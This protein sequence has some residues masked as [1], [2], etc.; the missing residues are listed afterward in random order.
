MAQQI[1]DWEARRDESGN[2][3][4]Y[5]PPRNDGGGSYE[6]AG[7]NERYHPTMAAR[8]KILLEA[9]RYAQAEKRAVEYIADYT[10]H[11]KDWQND[12]GIELF[13]RDCCFNRGPAGAAKILQLAVSVSPDGK[14]GPI[15]R[16]AVQYY[17]FRTTLLL[18]RLRGARERYEEIAA[19]NRPNLRAGLEDRWDKAF[20]AAYDLENTLPS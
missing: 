9:K 18:C 1:V 4:V 6:I 15:T 2:L 13:L 14:V 10:E 20:D 8:L 16:A 3:K 5:P 12:P 11:V 17:K 7:I 19:P